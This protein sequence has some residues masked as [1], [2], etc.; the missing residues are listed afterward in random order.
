VRRWLLETNT[1]ISAINR[2]GGVRERVNIAGLDGQLL[3]STISV[4]EML[5]GAA[6]SRRPD[7]NRRRVFS[8]IRSFT[9]LP[10]D[11]AAAERLAHIRLHFERIGKR[12]PRIDLPP[13]R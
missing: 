8:S 2:Q 1:L 5:Y 12:R 3:A 4:A 11:L 7:E 13:C 9:V 6:R 10:F